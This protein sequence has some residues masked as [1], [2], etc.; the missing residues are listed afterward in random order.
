L[1]KLILIQVD[2]EGV[3]L[4]LRQCTLNRNTKAKRIGLCFRS[5]IRYQA[6][7]DNGENGC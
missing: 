5:F 2:A 6:D 4:T 1:D 3:I 7:E